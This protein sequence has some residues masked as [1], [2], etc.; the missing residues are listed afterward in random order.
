MPEKKVLRNVRNEDVHLE[1]ERRARAGES[2]RQLAVIVFVL[3]STAASLGIHAH[4][5][6]YT[7]RRKIRKI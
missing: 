2:R 3:Q 1:M 6:L 5:Y 7:V 4:I